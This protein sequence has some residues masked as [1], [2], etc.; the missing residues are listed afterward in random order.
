MPYEQGEAYMVHRPPTAAS[1]DPGRPGTL[2]LGEVHLFP[3]VLVPAYD[4]ARV[5]AVQEQ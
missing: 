3:W 1:P 2:S 5:V 4:D